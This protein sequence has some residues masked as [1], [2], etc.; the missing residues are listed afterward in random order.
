MSK[1]R[2]TLA[3][4][5]MGISIVTGTPAFADAI[6]FGSADIGRSFG[7]SFDG[8]SDNI[9]IDGLSSNATFTLA[10]ITSTSYVFDYSIANTSSNGVDSR[11]SSFAFNVDPAISG[12]SSTGTFDFAVLDSKYPNGIGNVDV[13]FKGGSSNSCGGNSGGVLTG[14]TGTGTVTLNFASAPSSVTLS[15]FLT[16]YQ[17]ISGAGNVTSASGSGTVS[18]STSSSSSGG[19]PVPEPGPLGV[20]GLGLAG[21]WLAHRRRSVRYSTDHRL[22]TA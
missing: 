2:N 12:A 16:R 10:D 22:A 8:F 6:T 13:C 19:T 11:V 14:D 4:L 9:T 15:E 21:L 3:A 18:S 17:S 7:V 5:A 20:F 1:M